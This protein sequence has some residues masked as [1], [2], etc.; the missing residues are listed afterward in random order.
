MHEVVEDH[1]PMDELD[2]RLEELHELHEPVMLGDQVVHE[3][4][5]LDEAAAAHDFIR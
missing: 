4:Q 2:E 5:T 3:V 1:T